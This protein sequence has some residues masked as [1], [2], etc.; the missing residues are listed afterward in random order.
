MSE[1]S[2]TYPTGM[3]M[4]GSRMMFTG[5]QGYRVEPADDYNGNPAFRVVSYNAAETTPVYG[6]VGLTEDDAH[7][8]AARLARP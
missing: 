6:G 2:N 1:R 5:P 3:S 4:I 7:D 8:L